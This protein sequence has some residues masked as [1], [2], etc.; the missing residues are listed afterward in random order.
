[1]PWVS[2]GLAAEAWL[3][4]ELPGTAPA[5]MAAAERTTLALDAASVGQ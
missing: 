4:G 5:A 3:R 2:S 1:L